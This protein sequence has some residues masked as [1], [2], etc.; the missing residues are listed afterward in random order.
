MPASDAVV[1]LQWEVCLQASSGSQVEVV[2]H[3]GDLLLGCGADTATIRAASGDGTSMMAQSAADLVVQLSVQVGEQAALAFCK[4]PQ[5]S[6]AQLTFRLQSMRSARPYRTGTQGGV[7]VLACSLLS[8]PCD[9]NHVH[10][11]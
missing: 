1:G 4:R 9:A 3:S 7:G 10:I 5:L 2:A 6:I 8:S 11:M